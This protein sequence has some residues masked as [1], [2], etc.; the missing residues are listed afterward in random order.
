MMTIPVADVNHYIW[1]LDFDPQGT[2]LTS[3]VL[4]KSAGNGGGWGST[5]YD[6]APLSDAEDAL[7]VARP[8]V[9]ELFLQFPLVSEVV[10]AV[11]ANEKLRPAVREAA[12]TL[13]RQRTDDPQALLATCSQL[14]SRRDA[15]AADYS[16]ALRWAEVAKR[17]L[18]DDPR[19]TLLMGA[20]QFRTGRI[21]EALATLAPEVQVPPTI[22]PGNLRIL[23]TGR[24]AFLILAHLRAGSRE[25][26]ESQAFLIMKEL[27]ADPDLAAANSSDSSFAV[28]DEAMLELRNAGGSPL[29]DPASMRTVARNFI[30]LLDKNLDGQI[31]KEETPQWVQG[32]LF[33]L[34]DMDEN[35][36]L[37]E[38]ELAEVMAA[39]PRFETDL[40]TRIEVLSKMIAKKPTSGVLLSSA[41]R[42]VVRREGVRQSAPGP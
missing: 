5:V 30:K 3:F 12:L 33:D 27:T 8:L 23:Q 14:V 32:Q 34:S 2:R 4:V 39:G 1:D 25:K 36:V 29:G 42:C 26:A 15:S 40:A 37:S 17:L 19:T 41:R 16:R 38:E 20:A 11:E 18:P 22:S 10:S 9:A 24:S 35:D 31:S 13:A 6:A 7:L 28:V 21:A